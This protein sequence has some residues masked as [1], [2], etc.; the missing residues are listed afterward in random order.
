MHLV[1][2]GCGFLRGLVNAIPRKEAK[3]TVPLAFVV[4]ADDDGTVQITIQLSNCRNVEL[5]DL[6]CGFVQKDDFVTI[7][8]AA[9]MRPAT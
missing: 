6:T 5:I 4:V 2:I 9:R 7:H 3:Q 1:P 8:D